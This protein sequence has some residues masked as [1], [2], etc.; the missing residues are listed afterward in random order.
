MKLLSWFV[1]L[2]L[3]GL[4]FW[5]GEFSIQQ[6]IVGIVR[7]H[8]GIEVRLAAAMNKPSAP[9][10]VSCP[11]PPS[12]SVPAALPQPSPAFHRLP[13]PPSTAAPSSRTLPHPLTRKPTGKR[14][15]SA[16]RHMGKDAGSSL[17]GAVVDRE[18]DYLS[19]PAPEYPE[20]ARQ[21]Q[22]QGLV[23]LDVI[24]GMDGRSEAVKISTGSGYY[25]LD[26]AARKAVQTYRFRPATIEGVKVR[27]HVRVPIRFHLNNNY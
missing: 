22:Q 18:P 17:A 6:P 7:G 23:V 1:S 8:N 3:H 21:Q 16:S 19:N 15:N 24:V 2:A 12:E 9:A 27:S 11:T 25:L 13:D 5:V 10:P 26:E 14:S 20:A 4:I